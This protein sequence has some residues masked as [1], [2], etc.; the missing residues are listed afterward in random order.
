MRDGGRRLSS[1]KFKVSEASPIEGEKQAYVGAIRRN[2]V[3]N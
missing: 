3:G 2:G 1:W